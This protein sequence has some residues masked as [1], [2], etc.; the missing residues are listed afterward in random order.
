[1]ILN[2]LILQKIHTKWMS[3][4]ASDNQSLEDDSEYCWEGFEKRGGKWI[5][6]EEN[7]LP[8]GDYE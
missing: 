2:I 3:K 4:S 6:A 5:R 7:K 1:M 8:D